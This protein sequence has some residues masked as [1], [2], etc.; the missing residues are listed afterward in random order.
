MIS[1]FPDAQLCGFVHQNVSCAGGAYVV[2]DCTQH[3]E[4]ELHTYLIDPS[5]SLGLQIKRAGKETLI[6]HGVDGLLFF[7][8]SEASF[9]PK[10]VST[11]RH[12]LK[13]FLLHQFN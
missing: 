1:G 3:T 7:Y 4:E 8:P 5:G 11:I 6:L 13:P 12:R 2:Y 10:T 9:Y